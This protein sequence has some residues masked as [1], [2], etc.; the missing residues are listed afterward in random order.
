M[1]GPGASGKEIQ[2]VVAWPTPALTT[3]RAI[4]LLFQTRKHKCESCILVLP[5]ADNTRYWQVNSIKV[6]QLDSPA[7]SSMT[8]TRK[9]EVNAVIHITDIGF[10]ETVAGA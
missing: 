10:Y 3:L 7:T 8:T 9:S 2:S 4:H 5:Y 6:Y 1:I